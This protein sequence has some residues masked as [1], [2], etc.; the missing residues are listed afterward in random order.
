MRRRSLVLAAASGMVVAFCLENIATAQD[1]GSSSDPCQGRLDARTAVAC[2]IARSPEI[3]RARADLR[4]LAGR[5]QSAE[6]W[7]PRLPDLEVEGSRRTPQDASGAARPPAWNWAVT[8]SQEL[9]LGGQRGARIQRA[10]AEMRAQLKR[11]VAAE[12]VVAA[13]AL[14]AYFEAAASRQRLALTERTSRIAEHLSTLAE[15]RAKES[16]ISGVDADVVQ[17]EALR[18]GNA[19]FEATRRSEAAAQLLNAL[20]GRDPDAALALGDEI[21]AV[22]TFPKAPE[23]PRQ[24]LNEAF[25]LRADLGATEL[26]RVVLE[27]ELRLIRRERIP[28]PRLSGFIARDEINDRL[29]GLRVAIPLPLPSPVWPSRAGEIAEAIARIE[30]AQSSSDLLRRRVEIEVRAAWSAETARRSALARYTPELLAR[31]G[32][33]LTNLAEAISSRQLGMRDALLAQ[34][35]LVEL[36]DAFIDA[37]LEYARSWLDVRRSAGIDLTGGV[38]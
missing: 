14:I 38:K 4:A 2:A 32:T 12:Q 36:L 35:S 23:D 16:L 1:R 5:R 31:A 28:N 8:L 34:R 18:V 19:R 33:D 11:V 37:R 17:A 20:T 9:E 3:R 21:D 29:L 6:V 25:D 15:A 7:L 13:E 30:A 22:A 27:A 26:E 10:D 24:L